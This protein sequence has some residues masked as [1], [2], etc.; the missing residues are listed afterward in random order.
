[1]LETV[2]QLSQR[3]GGRDRIGQGSAQGPASGVVVVE[4]G[5]LGRVA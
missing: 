1:L 4:S 2:E 3:I 5:A